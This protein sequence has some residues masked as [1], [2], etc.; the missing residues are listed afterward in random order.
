[1][2]DEEWAV[3][4]PLVTRKKRRGPKSRADLRQVVNAIRYGMRTGCQWRALPKEYGSCWRA[5]GYFYRWQRNGTLERVNT[6][7]RQEVRRRAGR[8]AEPTAA[9]MDSQ[10]VKT[11]QKGLNIEKLS[12]GAT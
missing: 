9:I 2:S 6:A 12:Y 8:D 5:Y 10:S 11:V 3:L 1:M 7:L 4:E